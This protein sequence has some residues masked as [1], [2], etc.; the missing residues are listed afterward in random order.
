LRLNNEPEHRT[1]GVF[2]ARSPKPKAHIVLI[3]PVESALGVP[4]Q[5]VSGFEEAQA[6][7]HLTGVQKIDRD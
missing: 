2:V 5:D 4:E 1:K 7:E 6:S 3:A